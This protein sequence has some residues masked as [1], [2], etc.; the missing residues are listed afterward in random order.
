MTHTACSWDTIRRVE[1]LRTAKAAAEA[2]AKEAAAKEAAKEVAAREAASKAAATASSL[3]ISELDSDDELARYGSTPLDHIQV[4]DRFYHTCL[5]LCLCGHCCLSLHLL[6]TPMLCNHTRNYAV[7]KLFDLKVFQ[8]PLTLQNSDLQQLCADASSATP[9]STLDMSGRELPFTTVSNWITAAFLSNHHSIDTRIN[10]QLTLLDASKDEWAWDLAVPLDKL[11][12]W[13]L[14]AH[15]VSI[16]NAHIKLP[17]DGVLLL[18]PESGVT[19]YNLTLEGRF[20]P[21][22]SAPPAMLGIKSFCTSC[23]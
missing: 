17:S 1:Q 20:M 8:P 22:W 6:R 21:C 16:C 19:F 5:I 10:P 9:G 14:S 7:Q 13:T 2:A 12:L 3:G 23:T 4:Q 11:H 15:D 18:Q